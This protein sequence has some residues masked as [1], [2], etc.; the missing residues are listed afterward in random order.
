MSPR[1]GAE[2]VLELFIDK[3]AIKVI[4]RLSASDL[5]IVKR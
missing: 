5:T 1:L 2:R 3:W 4:H